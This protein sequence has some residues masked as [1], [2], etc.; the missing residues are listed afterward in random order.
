[1]W[2]KI[3]DKELS[4]SQFPGFNYIIEFLSKCGNIEVVL[5]HAKWALDRNQEVAV[6]VF[7]E[8]VEGEKSEQLEPRFLL[9]FLKP[10]PDATLTYLEYLIN[11]KKS[12]V[13]VHTMY[14]VQYS[15]Q[16]LKPKIL[17]ESTCFVGGA[18]P[19]PAGRLLPAAAAEA[20]RRRE[21]SRE[22]AQE[23]QVMNASLV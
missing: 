5:Q 17:T 22:G 15:V 14:N 8:R 18:L 21:G 4:D 16:S 20:Q 1:M 3:Y 11:D 7:T 9:D 2:T 12:M 6:R 19:H 13:C 23:D 10:Y